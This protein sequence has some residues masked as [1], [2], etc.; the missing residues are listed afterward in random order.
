MKA[1]SS[2]VSNFFVDMGLAWLELPVDRSPW[3]SF[4]RSFPLPVPLPL[5]LFPELPEFAL[6]LGWWLVL[7]CTSL[8]PPMGVVS[9]SLTPQV[10][11]HP[12]RPQ[13]HSLPLL[14]HVQRGHFQLGYASAPLLA[15]ALWCLDRMSLASAMRTSVLASDRLLRSRRCHAGSCQRSSCT[16]LV[17]SSGEGRGA[18][19]RWRAGCAVAGRTRRA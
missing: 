7:C 16:A 15:I 3:W 12:R 13:L 19:A 17:V 14:D 5:L 2:L 8:P 1:F 11:W 10:K 9:S 6:T 18:M 4:W